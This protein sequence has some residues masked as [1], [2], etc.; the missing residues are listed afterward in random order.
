MQ[1]TQKNSERRSPD[2]TRAQ[3]QRRDALHRAGDKAV[4]HHA[5][6]AHDATA[7]E[8]FEVPGEKALIPHVGR[9]MRHPTVGAGAAIA[10]SVWQEFAAACGGAY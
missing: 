2:A 8:V 7:G 3:D 5:A 9:L 10:V 6:D 1:A 4:Q